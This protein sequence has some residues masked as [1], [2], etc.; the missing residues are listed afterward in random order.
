MDTVRHRSILKFQSTLLMRGATSRARPRLVRHTYFNPRSSCEERLVVA[1]GRV[2]AWKFQ[3]TLLMRGATP[4][5]ATCGIL[6]NFNPRSSCEE[7]QAQYITSSR[8]QSNFNPRSSCEERLSID[9]FT[10]P[11][12]NDFNP[13]SSCEERRFDAAP[14]A[15]FPE[16]SIHAPHARSDLMC[17]FRALLRSLFQSTLLM[18]GATAGP[19][20]RPGNPG[21]F[22]PRSSCEERLAAAAGD[23]WAKIFQSTLLMRGATS[24][25]GDFA[26]LLDDFNPRSSCEER[27]IGIKVVAAPVN[28]NPRSSCEERPA[29]IGG[30]FEEIIEFQSTLLMRGATSMHPT[31]PRA[32]DFNPR[33]SCEERRPRRV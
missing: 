23:G 6:P 17:C 10:S 13:R 28:F 22:N 25:G 19:D 12:L 8:C 14:P 31:N 15:Q 1:G 3:S 16:I 20:L 30:W 33:S 4:A 21:Y 5:R 9:F 27:L 2:D 26:R 32:A 7:R 18:R 11:R 29:D 24:V